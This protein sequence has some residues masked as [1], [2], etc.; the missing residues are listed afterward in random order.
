MGEREWGQKAIGGL[1]LPSGQ[2]EGGRE[3]PSGHMVPF[4][5]PL[6]SGAR[7]LSIAEGHCHPPILGKVI[8]CSS[9]IPWLSLI[10]FTT[11]KETEEAWGYLLD[12][13]S[14][15]TTL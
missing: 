5:M 10:C 2:G 15:V 4:Q 1:V 12:S 6:A 11:W 14:P 7:A 13:Q 3:L 9:S 8:I